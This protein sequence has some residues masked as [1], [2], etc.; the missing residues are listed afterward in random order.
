MK[1]VTIVAFHFLI[2]GQVNALALMCETTNSWFLEMGSVKIVEKQILEQIGVNVYNTEG[3]LVLSLMI[4]ENSEKE[5]ISTDNKGSSLVAVVL[6]DE[7]GFE[8]ITK[9]IEP[10]ACNRCP[11]PYRLYGLKGS[12]IH[13]ETDSGNFNLICKE[14]ATSH[15]FL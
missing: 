15:V 14:H 5:E 9:W 1:T 4:R 2:V 6:Q 8:N 3:E 10:L 13:I 11:P 12:G 7:L